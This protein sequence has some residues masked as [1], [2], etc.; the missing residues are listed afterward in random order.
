MKFDMVA[1]FRETI[2]TVKSI[3]SSEIY[4]NSRFL[5]EIT[6][7]PFFDKIIIFSGLQLVFFITSLIV[8]FITCHIG[9]KQFYIIKINKKTYNLITKI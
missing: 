6:I 4:K 2:P 5:T 3:S 8:F 1:R 9:I 7:L